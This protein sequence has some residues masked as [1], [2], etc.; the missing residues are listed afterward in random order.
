VTDSL[1]Q[2]LGRSVSDILPHRYPFLLVDRITE[3][4]P[5]QRITAHKHFSAN[6]ELLQGYSPNILI[7]A[8]ILFELVT[9]LGAVLVMERPQM[10]GKVPVILHISLARMYQ[11]V[12]PGETL[13]LEVQVLKIRENFGELRGVIYREDQLVG[14]GQMR[15]AIAEKSSLKLALDGHT[16]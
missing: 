4:I 1:A 15:F 13:H 12:Q 2:P 5:G 7:P 6:D 16:T 3:F 14:E 8:G 11:P 10:E 9:Q